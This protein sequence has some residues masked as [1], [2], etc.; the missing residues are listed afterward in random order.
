MSSKILYIKR[1]FLLCLLTGFLGEQV[2]AQDAP[3]YYIHAFNN[4]FLQNPATAGINNHA[5]FYLTYHRQE[6]GV[7]ENLPEHTSLAFHAP[8]ANTQSAFGANVYNFRRS[9]LNTTGATI[10]Y[11]YKV[12]FGKNQILRFGLSGGVQSNGFDQALLEEGDPVVINRYNNRIRPEGQFGIFYQLGNLGIGAGLPTLFR[13]PRV[14]DN[15][16]ID[17]KS[18]FRNSLFTATY[19][20]HIN[21]S[22]TFKP[23]VT[24]RSFEFDDL[25][26]LEASGTFIFNEQFWAGASYREKYG[27]AVLAGISLKN[28]FSV[29]YAY[30]IPDAKTNNYA[31][32]AHE[33]QLVLHLKRKQLKKPDFVDNPVSEGDSLLAKTEKK[34]PIKTE[35][36]ENKK[37]P[38][39]VKTE[40]K[41]EPEKNMP[42][43]KETVQTE[44]PAEKTKI[45]EIKEP[46]TKEPD[47]EQPQTRGTVINP[48]DVRIATK[49][50]TANDLDVNNYVVLGSFSY[51]KNAKSYTNTLRSETY[52][53]RIGYNS[54]NQKHYVYVFTSDNLPESLVELDK[55]RAVA[56]FEEAWILKIEKAK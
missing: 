30:K 10:A 45:P 7:P 16:L 52:N 24:Y 27:M 5:S 38:I 23:L 26:G 25:S 34:E 48:K 22:F 32:P 53:A 20:W 29:S 43:E 49:G 8:I 42:E 31:N 17:E 54:T 11:S 33:I 12:S 55:V 2:Q 15:S 51:E 50:N 44:D 18:P 41:K 13:T 19:D 40:E 28:A 9:F 39:I 36:E 3:L 37:E 21:K 6:V 4:L 14:N 47:S 46:E 56:G 35:K 1:A